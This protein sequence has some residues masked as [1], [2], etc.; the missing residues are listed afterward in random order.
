MI[1][2]LILVAKNSLFLKINETTGAYI[3]ISI[4]VILLFVI[5]LLIR[6]IKKSTDY[7]V[8]NWKN[9]QRKSIDSSKLRSLFFLISTT[10]G[11]K[12]VFGN[13]D[14]LSILSNTSTTLGLPNFLFYL[15]ISLII[16]EVVVI[17]F[18]LSQAKLLLNRKKDLENKV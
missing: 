3:L 7:F 1:L 11:S 15:V 8:D 5:W 9:E 14:S 18:L 4:L 2:P 6:H 10:I 16:L 13:N 12:C 17:F